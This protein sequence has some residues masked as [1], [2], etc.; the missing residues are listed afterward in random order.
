MAAAPDGRRRSAGSGCCGADA[1]EPA[2]WLAEVLALP[3]PE[4][5][6]RATLAAAYAY[7]AIYHFSR[8][9]LAR[10]ARSAEHAPELAKG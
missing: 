9:D 6:P 7:D 1:G 10:A 8:Q 2:A 3:G 4:L 5:V